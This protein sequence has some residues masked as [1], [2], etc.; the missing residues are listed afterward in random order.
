MK[1]NSQP[2]IVLF[3]RTEVPARRESE[4]RPRAARSRSF[5]I[6]CFSLAPTVVSLLSL[7]GLLLWTPSARA[8]EDGCGCEEY[9]VSVS[10]DYAH[11]RGNASVNVAGA[12]ENA[13]D[14]REEISGRNFSVAVAHLPAGKYTITIGEAETLLSGRGERLFDVTVGDVVLAKNF[15][16][17]TAA[18]GALKSW[19]R[20]GRG[21][22]RR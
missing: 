17:V 1:T 13:A 14:F 21:A 10:G 6:A 18:G 20:Y 15:D 11:R 4:V 22:A 9:P 8:T 19:R 2:T 5:D 12:A 3:D 7:A 16:I